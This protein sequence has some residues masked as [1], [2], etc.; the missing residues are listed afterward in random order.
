MTP[1]DRLTY[2][3][4]FNGD[5]AAFKVHQPHDGEL[6]YHI[7]AIDATGEVIGIVRY[8]CAPDQIFK[9]H[10]MA[11]TLYITVY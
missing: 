10:I 9:V 3:F 7:D 2:D 6:A 11:G 5:V 4:S 8:T 1:D